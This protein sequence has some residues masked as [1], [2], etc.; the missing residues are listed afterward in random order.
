MFKKN[1]LPKVFANP[2]NKELNNNEEVF[3]TIGKETRDYKQIDVPRRIKEIFASLNHVYKSKV[4][5]VTANDEFD[6]VIVGKTDHDLL[7]LNGEKIN[8]HSILYIE[9][10]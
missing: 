3:T 1:D 6:A 5:I 8:I 4:H 2:I 9:K 7:T 10:I